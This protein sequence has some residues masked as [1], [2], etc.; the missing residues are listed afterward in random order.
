[1]RTPKP[2]ARVLF[3]LL[4]ALLASACIQPVGEGERPC[5]CASGWTC[6][7]DVQLCV[8][9]PARC[10]QL[11]P[12]EPLS[13]T[14]TPGVRTVAL[15]WA[16]PQ[17]TG[18][19]DLIGFDVKVIPLEEG[20]LVKLDG[21]TARVEGLRAG[22]TYRFTVAARNAVGAGPAADTGPVR[23]PDVPAAPTG[24]VAER[25]D[26]KARVSWRAPV[27]DLPVLRYLVTAHPSNVH[28]EVA[29]PELSAQVEGL[30]NG[31]GVTFTV[32][33]VNAVGV[34][35]Q[36]IASASVVPA[37]RP[38]A[39]RG[40]SATPTVRGA[41]VTWSAPEDSGGVPVSGYVVM[42]SPGALSQQVDGATTQA[43]LTGLANDATYTFMV[44]PRNE[45]GEGPAAVS[46]PVRTPALPGAPERVRA[47][48]D[49]RSLVV[50]WEPPA[51]SGR[52]PITGY[53]V[54]AEPRGESLDVDADTRTA[55]LQD[56]PSTRAQTVTVT[57]RN[58]VGEGPGAT[59]EKPLRSLPAPV[60]VSQVVVPSTEGGCIGVRYTLHQPDGERADVV[61]EVDPEGDGTFL[62]ARQAGSDT[63]SG[64]VAVATSP[65]GASHDFLWNRS[66][67]LPGEALGTRV[68][69]TATVPGT[70]PSSATLLRPLGAAT[71]RC[72]LGLDTGPLQWASIMD[73][74]A[75]ALALTHGDFD[76]DGKEDVVVLH[77]GPGSPSLM[78][79]LGNGGFARTQE[80]NMSLGGE[81]LASADLDG[82]G[83]LDLVAAGPEPE[84]DI[85]AV[86]VALGRGDGTFEPP[87]STPL[88]SSL[89]SFAFLP[90]LV[91]DLDGDG[92]PE[93]V[94]AKTGTLFVLRQTG[95]GHLEVAF[96]EAIGAHGHL[97]GGD[98]DGDGR[99]DVMMVGP[100]LIAW[101]GLGLLDFTPE[102]LGPLGDHVSDA[103]V[104]DFNGDGHLDLA[105]NVRLQDD[106]V[107]QLR[108]GDGE[109]RFGGST[110]LLRHLVSYWGHWAQLAVADLD[111]DGARDLA[112]LNA[113]LNAAD[114]LEGHGDGTFDVRT[115]PTAQYQNHIALADFDGSGLPDAVLLSQDRSVRVLPDLEPTQRAGFGVF[116]A[117]GDFDGD[118]WDDV[119]SLDDDASLQ[120]HLTRAT[121]GPV[122][123][124]PSAVPRGIHS[125]LSGRFDANGTTD[126]LLL[127]I[128]RSN[129][130]R[131]LSLLRGLG[132][133]TF[134]PSEPI[135]THGEPGQV[136]T[137]DVD[138]DGDLDVVFSVAP[139]DNGTDLHEVRLLRGN[140]DGT[141]TFAG[142]VA[143]HA[144]E[145][146]LSLGDLNQDGR[147][148]LV[149]LRNVALRAELAFYEGRANG[150]LVK[151]SE[152][153]P[154]LEPCAGVSAM[155]GDLNQDGRVDVVVSCAGPAFNGVLPLMGNG[156]FGFNLQHSYVTGSGANRVAVTDL[157]R[158][159]LKDLVVTFFSDDAVCLFRATVWPGGQYAA[160]RC[161]GILAFSNNPLV[162]DLEHD[163]VP[164]LLVT[165]DSFLD[166]TSL[167]RVR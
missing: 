113:D 3:L 46:A 42:A 151:V 56:I 166:G 14:V 159:G 105:A 100:T 27:T 11:R 72:E 65:K 31:E 132:D 54:R 118:G 88:P 93:V 75:A 143:T 67:Q 112:Y 62:R 139:A 120:V 37:G 123:R 134:S 85:L 152:Y 26:R 33:A 76:R 102:H 71:R 156:R 29:A 22:A 135:E 153:A 142:V 147:A 148:D 23:L 121:G 13:L 91:R 157:D 19:S 104:A 32:R 39:P 53:T 17:A 130:R 24:L 25:G 98:F 83:L 9:T 44:V 70:L 20:A 82:D 2:A 158:D 110:E 36:S 64:L 84:R 141:F 149:L 109:G 15:A 114:V 126:L 90:L 47:T 49:V 125:L 129:G 160:P 35:P 16:D 167:L 79:G 18:G 145:S 86:R 117:L 80:S 99:E 57:A 107:L 97:A 161:F 8:S 4:G 95:G 68:R 115:V 58:A 155:L 7:E 59:A 78:R 50:T 55:T 138:G 140:G 101:Y 154:S 150:T 77:N 63:V 5:P 146:H 1:M 163:G 162:L 52:A 48:P 164:E 119:A 51:S 127:T 69:V 128:Q 12:S 74:G 60:Q 66:W 38:G 133:G 81:A 61:V 43:T 108:L 137:G 96:E 73:P 21:R 111:R 136:T 6:C 106:S 92:R 131:A 94:L 41:S 122:R 87:V 124:G 28:V 40:V 45:V 144:A 30:T 34:G 165:S 116:P 89:Q 103:K 10:E